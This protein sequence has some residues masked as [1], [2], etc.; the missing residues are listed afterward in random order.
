MGILSY[1]CPNFRSRVCG[2]GENPGLVM[3]FFFITVILCAACLVSLAEAPPL[4]AAPANDEAGDGTAGIYY[5]DTKERAAGIVIKGPIDKA[6]ARHTKHLIGILRPDVDELTIYLDSPGGD[7]L[8]AMEIGEEVRNQWAFTAMD[9]DG[10]CLGACV[11]VL[12]A[13]ARRAPAADR[14]GLRRL[15]LDAKEPRDRA[16][17]KNAA[18]EKKVQAYLARMGMPKKL[19]QDMMQQP[20]DK[21]LLLNAARLKTLGL[22]G[23]DPAFEQWQRANNSERPPSSERSPSSD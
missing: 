9:D 7:V 19:F 1:I 14:V 4:V 12:A 20:S 10:E 3:R 5:L 16:G 6:V 18:I 22:E 17:Q 11:L 13:G 21:A 2:L 8:A 23:I 15:S